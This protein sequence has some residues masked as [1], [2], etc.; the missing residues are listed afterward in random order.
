MNTTSYTAI[1]DKILPIVEESLAYALKS[2]SSQHK[3]AVGMSGGVDSSVTLLL[4][5]ELGL[6]VFGV[7]MR[8]WNE[9]DERGTCLAEY[10]YQDVIKVCEH[11]GVPYYSVD[12]SQEYQDKVFQTFLEEIQSGLTPNPDV[13]CNKEIKFD[14]FW[15]ILKKMGADFIATGH[16]AQIEKR[17][18][19]LL[20]KKAVDT[21]KDQTYFLG[22]MPL[23]MLDKTL[24]PIGCLE[25]KQ[26]R[27]IAHAYGLATRAKKDS[28]GICFIGE[29]DFK[30]FVAQYVNSLKG[31]F[32]DFHSGK[33]LGQHDGSCFYTIGQRKGLGIG[34]PMGPWFVVAKNTQKNIVYVSN[35]EN[36]PAL[37]VKGCLANKSHWFINPKMG[38]WN[39][40]SCKV[41]YRQ[42]DSQVQF[43]MEDNK[44]I[45][46]FLTPQR[47]VTPGQYIVFYQD[48][49]CMG[50]AQITH[51]IVD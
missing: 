37:F 44:I 35:Q 30:T 14:A 1:K 33:V 40:V 7:F 43:K 5:K 21:S 9:V 42:Q 26:V 23:A 3:I 47:A 20:L 36:D 13:L 24:F 15:S 31:D 8:N 50:S 45:S 49:Y 18:E 12:L 22:Q 48:L 4:L 41:R 25:K 6:N 38:E 17:D 28:T 32:V 10:E 19:R 11:I 46:N 27:E 51:T 39:T 16:Y 2:I 34:G 29:R